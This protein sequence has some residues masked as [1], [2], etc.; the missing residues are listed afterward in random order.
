MTTCQIMIGLA[1]DHFK[2]TDPSLHVLSAMTSDGRR[3]AQ[4]FCRIV[5]VVAEG[6]YRHCYQCLTVAILSPS[7]SL[8]P[9]NTSI[10]YLLE[11]NVMVSRFEPRR[12]EPS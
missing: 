1:D 5:L 7:S 6:I 9:F 8:S 10:Q 2:A 4:L 12:A 11:L 3:H